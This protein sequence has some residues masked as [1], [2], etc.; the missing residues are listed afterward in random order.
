MFV[1]ADPRN[2]V[3]ATLSVVVIEDATGVGLQNPAGTTMATDVLV[4]NNG[5]GVDPIGGTIT[6]KRVELSGNTIDT[7]STAEPYPTVPWAPEVPNKFPAGKGKMVLDEGTYM[8][9]TSSY[10]SS[11]C[12]SL[13]YYYNP[14][15]YVGLE[16]QGGTE[17]T[18]SHGG[19]DAPPACIY[20]GKDVSCTGFSIEKAVN[21]TSVQITSIEHSGFTVRD[22]ASFAWTEVVTYDCTGD[23]CSLGTFPCTQDI[24]MRYDRI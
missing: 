3:E 21:E 10:G 13:P 16:W 11:T 12:T 20:D 7:A 6:E 4:R 22:K 1:G 9:F 2:D 15:Q 18:V 24:G 17:F 8:M 19:S 5:V 23:W 14:S